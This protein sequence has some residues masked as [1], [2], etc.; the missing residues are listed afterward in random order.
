MPSEVIRKVY[1]LSGLKIKFFLQATR[2]RSKLSN[3]LLDSKANRKAVNRTQTI[4]LC[5]KPGESALI[6]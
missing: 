2:L 6:R 1:Y 5:P 3:G 4:T